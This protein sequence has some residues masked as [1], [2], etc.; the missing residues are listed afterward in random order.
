MSL[1]QHLVKF[2]MMVCLAG[3]V[4]WPSHARD[5]TEIQA[6]INS[7]R[8]NIEAAEKAI[9]AANL[10]VQQASSAIQ[11]AEKFEGPH[12][13][14]LEQSV[15]TWTTVMEQG[16]ATI[17]TNARTIL[18][19]NP[20]AS[21][22]LRSSEY[23]GA[24][25]RSLRDQLR[26]IQADLTAAIARAEQ[27][28][29][30]QSQVRLAAL[31][32][33]ADGV[34]NLTVNTAADVL[35]IPTSL[36]DAGGAVVIKAAEA[37][38]KWFAKP[39]DL[40]N[41][42]VKFVVG[43]YYLADETKSNNRVIR[44]AN[45]FDA[46][47]NEFINRTQAD[48][49]SAQQGVD[50]VVRLWQLGD[51]TRSKF[52][53]A[54]SGWRKASEE[55]SKKQTEEAVQNFDQELARPASTIR[56]P[57]YWPAPQIP[58]IEASEYEPEAEGML[59]E[60]RS[61]AMAA[62]DGGS[63]LTYHQIKAS[64]VKRLGEKTQAVSNRLDATRITLDQASSA[65]WVTMTAAST[66]YHSCW[67]GCGGRANSGSCY[68]SCARS[69]S[70]IENSARAAVVPSATA[71]SLASRELNRLNMIAGLHR[72]H[73][74]ALDH[75]IRE[76]ADG[77]RGRYSLLWAERQGQ[78]DGL[79]SILGAALVAI[80]TPNTL[81]YYKQQPQWVQWDIDVWNR[82][83][84]SAALERIQTMAQQLRDAE[85]DAKRGLAAYKKVLPQVLQIGQQAQSELN[86]MQDRLGPLLRYYQDSEDYTQASIDEH[87]AWAKKIVQDRFTFIEPDYLA[88]AA[89][90]P[91]EATAREVEARM[92]ELND[93]VRRM[94]TFNF[95]LSNANAALDKASRT[96]TKQPLYSNRG[97][98]SDQ[99]SSSTVAKAVQAELT[100]GSW[101]GFANAVQ[102]LVQQDHGVKLVAG[103]QESPVQQLIMFQ[104]S[105]LTYVN[106]MMRDYVSAAGQGRFAHADQQ[107]YEQVEKIWQSLK[108]LYALHESAAA[109]Q[110]TKLTEAQ[111]LFPNETNLHKAYAAVPEAQRGVL[112]ER[113]FTYRN[114]S[115]WLRDYHTR[116]QSAVAPL[117]HPEKNQV[118]ARLQGLIEGYPAAKAQWERKEAEARALY[119]RQMEEYRQRQEA[120]AK[121]QRAREEQ[122]R[123]AEQAGIA[124]VQ[125]LYQDFAS[126]Y[127][128]RNLR[129]LLRF[130]SDGWVASDGSD[131]R[132]LEDV[133][134]NSFR[135]FDRVSFVISGLAIQPAGDGRY[136]VS[137]STNITGHISQMNI[138]HQESAQV[139]DTVVLTST[140][141]KIEAT[142]GGR[143]W[144]KQ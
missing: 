99:S 118:M 15:Q 8:Q 95:R 10:K 123:Q 65:Y 43:F 11:N 70:A 84:P 50:I 126:A 49:A 128:A 109:P 59:R 134:D 30:R 144:I 3:M 51:D 12:W 135:V 16:S 38:G 45:E 74:D 78:M 138:K 25:M 120:E 1:R 41:T 139:Q 81:A 20:S 66:A 97:V 31:D 133:L 5:Y 24:S 92:D 6:E 61:A 113:Y 28:K 62:I 14:A 18:R 9:D 67:R 131:L 143:I 4:M 56:S 22:Y 75:I 52:N 136:N 37:A 69:Y 73:S 63:P 60:L 88:A 124:S 91:Y 106:S 140:G 87:I 32:D 94:D 46:F 80:P 130:M 68:E 90:F 72:H 110:R 108:P 103:G 76:A 129:G 137:Y 141:L 102:T 77:A 7:A 107:V 21:V 117:N 42:G 116:M 121:A 132:D 55:G 100:S 96:L 58:D 142:R 114:E 26:G 2:T 125:K 29:Q 89:S 36:G 19:L 40:A 35:G 115:G 27:S 39:I 44:S 23:F 104:G 13:G 93:A 127:Q 34:V 47:A 54:Q 105:L 86:A 53:Q 82:R 79:L 119:E 71:Y 17:D 48:I 83:D 98:T 122:A 111:G 33:V 101:S 64:Q 112:Q 57:T 85:K